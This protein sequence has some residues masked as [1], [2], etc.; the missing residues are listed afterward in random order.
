MSRK[1]ATIIIGL[2]AA[3]L[4]GVA[5]VTGPGA[6]QGQNEQGSVLSPQIAIADDPSQVQSGK[7]PQFGIW[8]AVPITEGSTD[9]S[10]RLNAAMQ[11]AIEQEV[12]AGVPP[13]GETTLGSTIQIAGK[14]V[15]LPSNV[16]ISATIINALCPVEVKC[17]TTPAYILSNKDTGSTIGVSIASGEIGDPSL[18]AEELSKLRSEFSWLVEAVEVV[19]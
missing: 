6:S 8:A 12:G 16:Y 4:I 1:Q 19:K 14:S 5:V 9:T 15:Q 10:Q 11:T 17:L 18:S 2:L 3:I 13:S 7:H